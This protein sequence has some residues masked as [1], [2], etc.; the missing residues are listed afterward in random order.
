MMERARL[1]DI[2][3]G[4]ER[5]R[6]LVIGDYFVDKYLEIDRSL[7]EISLETGLVAHQVYAVRSS[8]GAAGTVVS[9]LRAL[10]V[11]VIALGVIGDD[12]EGYELLRALKVSG[13]D[14][15]AMLS[16]TERLTP[17]Y[18]KPMMHE[19]GG[20]IHEISRLDIKNRS[21]L[22]S[23]LEDELIA[24]L[25]TLIAD[26]DGCARRSSGWLKNTRRSS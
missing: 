22:P 14:T 23:D 10:G 1:S 5:S 11:G 8:P 7:A 21:P 26:V 18:M 13:V 19:A 2:L 17:T 9:N 6:V 12:G 25:G 15:E 20:R 16:S 4:F 3:A 24:H